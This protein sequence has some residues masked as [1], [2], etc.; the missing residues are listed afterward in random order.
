MLRHVPRFAD[1]G[2]IREVSVQKVQRQ[3]NMGSSERWE[4]QPGKFINLKLGLGSKGG[5]SALSL[6]NASKGD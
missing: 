5:P 1:T 3:N 4:Q 6:I 2:N